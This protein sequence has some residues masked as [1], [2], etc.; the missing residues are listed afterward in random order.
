MM[1]ALIDGHML[2]ARE[3]GN[4][5]YIRGLLSGLEA[6]G[7]REVVAVQ[8]FSVDVGGHVPV[9]LPRC[10]DAARL[11]VHLRAAARDCRA[12]VVHSTYAAPFC[13]G[14][15]QV[16]TVHDVS[17]LA[18]PEW[19][20]IRDRLVLNAGVRSSVRRAE[21]VI[22]P[23]SHARDE[24]IARLAV[25][26][27]RVVIT[28]EAADARFRPLG[29]DESAPVLRRYGLT[30]PF[31]L[32]VGNQQP[33]KNL[34]RLL[35]AW[36]MLVDAGLT[37]GRRLAIAG[38]RRGRRDDLMSQI[39]LREHVLVLGYVP[40][41]DVPALYSAADVFVF[42][43]L[44]EGF[45]LP[46]LEAMACGTPVACSTAASLPEAAGDAAAFFDPLDVTGMAVTLGAVVRDQ[47]LRAALSARG[48][49]HAALFTWEA[50]A[51]AT[52]AA[53]ED[54]VAL[55]ERRRQ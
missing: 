3:T 9:V 21:R 35:R 22:V 43:S 13:V 11:L 37:D 5:T 27:R 32:S 44:Y 4:E 20:T 39:G 54:A 17:F 14:C 48:R 8:S 53:Y 15:A 34:G 2:G 23:S 42:P 49:R 51:R 45:G 16:V 55:R 29:D 26:T 46:P 38:G 25:P 33:R 36:K 40:H 52:V 24:L 41:E 18:H 47:E 30:R 1:R 31:V 19:F 7:R 6:M 50:C 10:S 12:D 28:P